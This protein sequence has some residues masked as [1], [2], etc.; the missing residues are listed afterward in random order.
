MSSIIHNDGKK[1]PELEIAEYFVQIRESD[2]N[3]FDLD[4][5]IVVNVG[6]HDL[7]QSIYLED[8]EKFRKI[9]KEGIVWALL[10]YNYNE[11][12][13]EWETYKESVR[14]DISPIIILPVNIK[15]HDIKAEKHEGKIITFNSDIVS[16]DEK[17]TVALITKW[18]CLDCGR[19]QTTGRQTYKVC[20]DCNSKE[21]ESKGI[22]NSESIQRVLLRE[23]MD[24]AKHSTQQTFVGKFILNM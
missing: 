20:I 2:I 18:L 1:D 15:L 7:I 16:V 19:E 3:D 17:E 5:P 14:Y 24:E 11:T 8:K 4:R 9:L 10:H 13:E 6:E 21:I 23:P 22:V 12:D